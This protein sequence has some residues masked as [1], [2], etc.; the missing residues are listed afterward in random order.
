MVDRQRHGHFYMQRR[1]R[2]CG[3]IDVILPR[4]GAPGDEGG[5]ATTNKKKGGG[6]EGRLERTRWATLRL[7]ISLI[8]LGVPREAA[9]MLSCSVREIPA[10]S[11]TFYVTVCQAASGCQ[12]KRRACQCGSSRP[13]ENL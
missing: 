12:S 4:L 10:Q 2:R 7:C 3:H 11:V 9:P 5:K 8:S 13:E 1:C 6:G